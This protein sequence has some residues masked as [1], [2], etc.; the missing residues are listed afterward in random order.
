MSK[1]HPS[2]ARG[3]PSE[4]AAEDLR[5][6]LL[7]AAEVRFAEQG[8]AAI[9]LRSL[10]EEVGVNPS[11]L[12][13]YFGSKHELML[14]VLHRAL[15]PLAEA[16]ATLRQSAEVESR[17]MTALLFR[18]I[19]A[20]PT[21]PRLLVREVLLGEDRFRDYFREHFAPRLGAVL[22]QVLRSEQQH[23]HLDPEFD[24]NTLVL[25]ILGLCLFPFV[26][27]PVAEPLL[28]V[29]YSPAGRERLLGQVD[30]I[31]QKGILP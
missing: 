14:A 11:L 10:A 23:G 7:D 16:V 19:S 21:L 25:M 12:H 18:A 3:R 24:A 5:E 29:D 4:P 9:S 15:E 22:A 20:H 26:A 31:L 30:R 8:Y 28:G 1:L 6:K 2:R 13:Y 27:Q 17:E